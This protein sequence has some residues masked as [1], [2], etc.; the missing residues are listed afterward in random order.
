MRGIAILGSTGSIGRQAIEVLSLHPDQ[1]HV[2][3][4]TAHQN[5]DLLFEQVRVLRPQMAALTGEEVPVP[6]DLSFCQ[7]YFG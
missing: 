7:F 4:L 5:A 1:F 2:T 3:A 6:A